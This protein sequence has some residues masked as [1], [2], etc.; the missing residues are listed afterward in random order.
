MTN[1]KNHMRY[2]EDMRVAK[3]LSPTNWCPRCLAH[4]LD[5]HPT[6][7]VR[8]K[9]QCYLINNERGAYMCMCVCETNKWNINMNTVN[10]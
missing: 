5:V 9:H 1:M 2:K 10:K 4:Y 7:W 6:E 3:D 8:W